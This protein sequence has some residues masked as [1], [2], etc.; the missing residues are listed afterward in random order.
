VVGTLRDNS[1]EVEI[2]RAH[3]W[4]VD[5]AGHVLL[6][7][8]LPTLSPTLPGATV[9][10]G[11][12][13]VNNQGV[14]VG[15]QWEDDDCPDTPPF[16]DTRPLL[17]PQ[18]AAAPIELPLPEGARGGNAD[19]INDEGIVMGTA[20]GLDEMILVAWKTAVVNGVGTVQD[21]Q[22][23]LSAAG[24]LLRGDIANSG[25]LSTTLVLSADPEHY[26]D[27]RA[28][29]L[30]LDWDD[31]EVWEVA[32]SRTQLFDFY[33]GASRVNEA[34]TVCG[35]YMDGGRSWAFAMN[36]AGDLLDLA[37]LPGGRIRGQTYEI[38]NDWAS[39]LNNA[40]PLQV[41][42]KA[43]I[44]IV[45]T[46]E[47]RGNVGVLWNVGT[48]AVNLNAATSRDLFPHDINDAGW[49]V[50]DAVDTEDTFARQPVV[51]IPS[52]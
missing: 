23:I 32:G 17:W 28:Y 6:S 16:L 46:F 47:G 2:P 44:V 21:T 27:Y 31:D 45:A 33:S 41:V 10:S 42:G 24:G 37:Q 5:A 15:Y 34:G 18:A 39:G 40:T 20:F 29:R 35:S 25:Y 43:S 30:R 52:R 13:A 3:Y 51:L 22:V 26:G 50:G 36:A 14:V 12:R 7:F 48:G 8:D 49:I 11:A 19:S 4:M 9:H 38:H 1:G